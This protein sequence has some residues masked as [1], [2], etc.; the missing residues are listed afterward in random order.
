[1]DASVERGAAVRRRS[2]LAASAALC[3]GACAS[4]PP[5]SDGEWHEVRLPGKE[6][7]VYRRARREG[8]DGFEAHAQRSA[9]MWRRKLDIAPERIGMV[10]FSWWVP[11]LM[12]ASSVADVDHEDAAARVLFGFGG[13]RAR[14][15][16]RTRMMFDLAEG[17]TGEAPPFATLMYVWDRVAPVGEV[18]IN[19]RS[20][21]IR[22][23]VVDSGSQHL[24]QWREHRRD[25]AAD[26]RRAFGED[27]GPLLSMALMTDADN[28]R[29]TARAWYGPIRLL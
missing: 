19:P 1:M 8:R 26:F 17:L 10:E 23:L 15:S 6:P 14:L 4:R 3:L 25:L 9:S 20:D 5:A 22:K 11:A 21:R 13:D 24:G 16:Q 28:T 7:T 12:P 18:V 2:L 29:S 27:P